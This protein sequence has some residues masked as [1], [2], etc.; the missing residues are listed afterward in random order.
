M[1]EQQFKFPE[2]AYRDLKPGEKFV[3]M[4][5]PS[6]RVPELTTRMFVFG[7]IMN[8]IFSVAATF[9]ALKAGQGIETAIPIS[10][11]AVGLSGLLLKAGGRASSILENLY[12]LSISTTSGYVAGGTCFTMPAIYILSLNSNLEMSNVALFLQIALVPF[13]GAILGALFLI[14][15]RRYFVKQMH[16]KL[17]FPEATATNEILVTGASGSTTQAW[18]LIYSFIL[19]A[20]YT[21]AATALKLFSDKFTTGYAKLEAVGKESVETLAFGSVGLFATLTTK[22]KAVFSMGAGAYYL[23]LGFIIGPRYASIICAGSLLSCFAIIPLMSNLDL[24]QLQMLNPACVAHHGVTEEKPR[25]TMPAGYAAGLDKFD[26]MRKPELPESIESNRSQVRAAF[27]EKKIT[28]ADTAGF[29]AYKLGQTWKISSDKDVYKLELSGN[30]IVVKV[31]VKEQPICKL[32]ATLVKNLDDS[33]TEDEKAIAQTRALFSEHKIALSEDAQFIMYELDRVWKILDGKQSYTLT[34]VNEELAVTGAVAKE[35]LFKL[36]ATFTATLTAILP[37]QERFRAQ[38]RAAFSEHQVTLTDDATFATRQLSRVWEIQS[39]RLTFLLTVVNDEIVVEQ[40]GEEQPIFRLSAD[41]IAHLDGMLDEKDRV[42]GEL[43]G[44]FADARHGFKQA[45]VGIAVKTAGSEWVLKDKSQTYELRALPDR[46]GIAVFARSASADEI[47]G[48]IPKNIGIGAIFTAGLLSILRMAGVIVTALRQALGSLFSRKGSLASDRTDE[49]FSYGTMFLLG[50]AVVV[51]LA[52]FF[53]SVVFADMANPLWLTFVSI[54][55]ALVI[56]FLFTTVSAWAIAMISVTPISGMTVTTIIIT[57]VLM[58][59][60]GLPKGDGAMLA[61]LLV[62]GVVCTGLSMAG[63]MITNYKMAYWLGA[64]PKRMTWNALLGSLVSAIFVCG[65]IMIL[66]I[67]PGY[68][69]PGK[70]DAPQANMMASALESFLGTGEVPWLLYGVGVMIALSMQLLNISPLAFG[71]G[72]YLPMYIN[73]PI[74]IGAF[75]SSLVKKSTKDE[76]LSKARNNK[77]ILLASGL[78]AGGAIMEVLVNFTKI[79]DE[80]GLGNKFMP[81]ID[82]SGRMMDGGADPESLARTQNWLGLILFLGLCLFVYLDC[83]RAKAELA[84][85]G[86]LGG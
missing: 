1:A 31:A 30:E 55:I 70:L 12:I 68:V 40:I 74:L 49:D 21:F 15:F 73:T 14:P 65:T 46:S 50:A 34:L 47:F 36:P 60:A 62:G 28:L 69:G 81:F 11:L 51:I 35:P 45:A 61:V 22:I 24:E 63:G 17:P 58:M 44:A 66:N 23:G 48:S 54:I 32:P 38:V 9:L 76:T 29:T 2:N 16:G 5:P 67:K 43:G 6:V 82:F 53:R 26:K 59:A 79:V 75:V 78:I 8:V 19:S 71:L 72:M 85:G 3:S 83:R 86:E 80:Y 10:I 20:V 64:S 25:F 37:E 41:M 57:A 27:E 39:G 56:T 77:G 52:I 33:L 18:I 42:R 84:A 13:L 4:I 7:L